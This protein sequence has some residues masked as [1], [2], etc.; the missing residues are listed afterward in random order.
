MSAQDSSTAVSRVIVLQGRGIVGG[1]AEGEALV[2]R[3]RI[4]GWG[5]IDPRTGTV[6]ET[7]HELRGVSFAGKVLVFPG[8]KGSSGWSGQFH[9]AR[10]SG[11]APA[12]MLFNEMTTKIALGAVV[13]HAPS[14]TDFD[15]DP[16]SV[17]ET[18][19][20]VRVDG[21][22]GRVEVAKRARG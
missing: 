21:D 5:G 4:S 14:V 22:L 16:L 18:G 8:A 15:I 11:M 9:I 17:I 13:T 1:R 3:D 10:I 7:R 19:D 6:I 12:A 20:W 2:T